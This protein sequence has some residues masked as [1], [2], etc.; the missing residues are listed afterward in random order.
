MIGTLILKAYSNTLYSV[1]GL[2]LVCFM[3]GLIYIMR[4]FR[5]S[6]AREALT[7]EMSA[8]AGDDV[9]ATQLDLAR[10]YLETGSDKLAKTIL[11]TVAKAGSPA[12]RLE[13]KRLLRK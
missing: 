3:S 9:M 12:Q 11:K 7:Q 10:A 5:E 13:A 8:I 2:A 1:G 6:D 4:F